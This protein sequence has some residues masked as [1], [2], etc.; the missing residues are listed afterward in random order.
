VD[1]NEAKRSGTTRQLLGSLAAA[2]LIVALAIWAVTARLGP[3]SIAER[4]AAEEQAEEAQEAA[5]E[6]ADEAREARD[7]G[8]NRRRGG[9]N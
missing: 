4:E 6:A 5:E 8:R 2:A 1:R 3:T 7:G 9:R